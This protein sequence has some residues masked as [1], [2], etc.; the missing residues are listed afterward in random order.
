MWLA[1]LRFLYRKM[2]KTRWLTIS[3]L[4]GLIIA[5]AFTTSIPMYA[6]GSLKRVVQQSLLEENQGLP[7]GALLI[8]YQTV[9]SDVPDLDSIEEVD[10]FIANEIPQRIDFPQHNYVRTYGFRTGTVYSADPEQTDNVRRRM[11]VSAM[12]HLSEHVKITSGEMFSESGSS[13]NVIE[14]VILEEGLYRNYLR[15]GEEYLYQISGQ[16]PITIKIVGTYEPEISSNPYDAYWYRGMDSF[17]NTLI[18]SEQSFKQLLEQG[19]PLDIANWFYNFDLRE[20]ETSQLAPTA[21]TLERLNLEL[22]QILRNTQIDISFAGMLK[23]FRRTS[24]QMQTM[25]LTLAAPMIAMVFYYIAMNS[26]QSLERQRSDIAVL[27]SRGASNKQIFFI[28]VLEGLVLGAA[29]LVAGPMLGW[30]MAKSIG[31]SSGFLTFVNRSALPVDVGTDTII[32][33][34]I[35]VFIA[36]LASVI[37]AIQYAKSTI[38]GLRQQMA[39]TNRKPFWQKFYL[40]IVLLGVSAYGW[41][42]FQE[43]QFLSLQ[44]GLSGDQMQVQPFLFFVPALAIFSLGLF[45]LR[46]FPLILRLIGGI[47]RRMLPVPLYLTLTQLSRS[48]KAYYPLML[49]LIMTLALGIYNASAARTIDLNSREQLLHSYGTDVIVQ[50]VWE[51]FSDVMPR[52]PGNQ[53]PG[54]EDGNED[55]GGSGNQPPPRN[56]YETPPPMHYVEPPFEVFR[57]LEGVEHAA[58]VLRTPTNVIVAGRSAGRGEMMAINNDEFARVAWFERRDL[59]GHHPFE[60]L[61]L[62][63]SYEQAALIPT[64]FAER[65]QLK[66]GDVISLT[67]NQVAIEFV[68]VGTVPYWPAQYPQNMPFF[69]VN[70]PYVYDEV[71]MIPYEVWIKMKEGAPITP[72]VEQLQEKGI[73]LASIKDV[74][75]ELLQ[76]ERLPTRGGIFGILSL[77]FLVS[78]LISLIGYVLYWFFNLSSRIVQFGILR[79]MGLKRRQLTGMLLLEQLFTAG[80]S[81]ALGF[82]IGKLASYLYLPFLQTTSSARLQ[83]PPFRI[84]FESRDSMQLYIVVGVMMLIGAG[85]LFAH[86][87]RLRVHQAVKLG[88]ER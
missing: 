70:M 40:D 71:P 51:G 49:L 68:V 80:L 64:N 83:V 7:A 47:G 18:I 65:Y 23:E 88:E 77:G 54:G 1:M 85:L 4:A 10:Q 3:T 28:Y 45:C 5:V 48:S 86:I 31:A 34:L 63:G 79:A 6:N 60:Y 38:V 19:I 53:P 20:I 22:Y 72:V 67:V 62:L 84:V 57:E 33:G 27:R 17:Y 2:W 24:L 46:L 41:Y 30:F 35:A 82:G 29:A 69:I 55:G 78:V 75:I 16:R 13:S 76:Q 73:P 21:T 50:A 9:G 59:F 58:R 61:N 36:M 8:R 87:R 14:A 25:L 12:S 43:R 39:R 37:P 52:D 11:A 32:Y 56:E 15:V 66:P 26:R 74:R 81:I 42:L 44:T